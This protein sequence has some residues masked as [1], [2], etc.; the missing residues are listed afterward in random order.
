MENV[1]NIVIEE[2]EVTSNGKYKLD[3]VW[4]EEIEELPC[5]ISDELIEASIKDTI[6][7]VEASTLY[8]TFGS[9]ENDI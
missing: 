1:I 7:K 9:K 5:D 4:T 2:R 3:G 6:K 8:G